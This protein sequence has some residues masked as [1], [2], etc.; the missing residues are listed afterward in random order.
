MTIFIRTILL[1]T[2]SFSLNL[3]AEETK[4]I[5]RPPQVSYTPVDKIAEGLTTLSPIQWFEATPNPNDPKFSE[6]SERF[7]KREIKNLPK[8]RSQDGMPLCGRFAA[9]YAFELFYC[10]KKDITDCSNLSDRDRMSPIDAMESDVPGEN[11]M[12]YASD[13][14]WI[15]NR[16]NKTKNKTFASEAC[17]PFDQV[18][19]ADPSRSE[20]RKLVP[21]FESLDANFERLKTE[22]STCLDCFEKSLVDLKIDFKNS[23]KLN[24]SKKEIADI[25]AKSNS[26]ANLVYKLFTPEKCKTQGRV[27]M[28]FSKIEWIHLAFNDREKITNYKQAMENINEQLE[29][30]RPL[31]INICVNWKHFENGGAFDFR[32]CAPNSLHSVLI[33]G[34]KLVCEKSS[35]V[36][37]WKNCRA[38]FKVANSWGKSWDD[39]SDGWVD[40]QKLLE[41]IN[42]IP[43]DNFNNK[44]KLDIHALNAL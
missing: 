16:F 43:V 9:S 12:V 28:P 23:I 42:V 41:N 32:K 29:L 34:S 21:Q 5:T 35:V 38:A 39:I 40:A 8:V 27:Q 24:L 17:S 33:V 10:Q 25:F 19:G 13:P 20:I 7:K 18:L 11:E 2:I 4:V 3:F 37:S 30:Q 22:A 26:P 6:Y 15:F 1:F 31:A 36:Q 14:L 44:K